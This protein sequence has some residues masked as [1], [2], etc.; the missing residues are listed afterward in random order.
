MIFA[1]QDISKFL[2]SVYGDLAK[3]AFKML[4]GKDL[5]NMMFG[6]FLGALGG[7][8][9]FF[10]V[11][12]FLFIYLVFKTYLIDALKK[13][14]LVSMLFDDYEF[15]LCFLLFFQAQYV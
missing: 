15:S 13:S 7:A 12:M 14:T 3:A 11:E 10:S 1:S 5:S 6:G 2:F 9:V 4:E 8:S